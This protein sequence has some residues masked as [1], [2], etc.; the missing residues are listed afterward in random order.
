MFLQEF[1]VGKGKDETE[2]QMKK[3]KQ[4]AQPQR[5]WECMKK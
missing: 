4:K 1:A 3:R 2:Q 5:V